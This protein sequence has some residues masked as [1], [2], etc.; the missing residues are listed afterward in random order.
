MRSSE[1]FI[2]VTYMAEMLGFE[3]KMPRVVNSS[4]YNNYDKCETESVA[5]SYYIE[6]SSFQQLTL[7]FCT[8]RT[9]FH[10]NS[11]HHNMLSFLLPSRAKTAIWESVK[12][13]YEK[14][15]CD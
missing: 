5:E 11:G 13:A 2:L 14:K 10:F 4:R 6:S 3:A 1:S 12:P 7:F 9:G 8:S 15:R